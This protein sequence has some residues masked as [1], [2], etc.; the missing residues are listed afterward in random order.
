M[1]KREGKRY[2]REK[3]EHE[4]HEDDERMH[5]ERPHGTGYGRERATYLEFLGRRWQGSEPPTPQAYARALRL[6][7]QLPGSV[8]TAPTDLGTLPES[9]PAG[10]SHP[11]PHKPA[12]HAGT[13]ERRS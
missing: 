7:R 3:H 2:E 6:W 1:N 11:S 12:H 5:R 13:K 10:D 8:V 4:G 9:P